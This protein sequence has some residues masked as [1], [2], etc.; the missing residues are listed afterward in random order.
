MKIINWNLLIW[1][2]KY[3]LAFAQL[4]HCEVC[5]T[6]RSNPNRLDYLASARLCRGRCP[7][8]DD[9]FFLK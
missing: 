5:F 6:N 7:R 3:F 8:N 1:I 2:S 4:C 9:N